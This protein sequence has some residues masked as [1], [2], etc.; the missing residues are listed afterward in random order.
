LVRACDRQTRIPT[1]KDCPVEIENL[2][3]TLTELD[4][5][6]LLN[7]LRR[8]ACADRLHAPRQAI[9]DLLNASALVPSRAVSPDVVTM[10][11]QVLLQDIQTHQR[12][13]LTLCYPA[14]AEPAAGFVSVLS[15]VGGALLGLR[16]GSIARWPTPTGEQR[17]AEIL[18][19]LF[20]P[21]SSGD[22][23]M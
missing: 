15:P 13:T 17:A 23:A 12:N 7:L 19:I 1:L 20:Q 21:E 9:E 22:Y 5:V 2:E 14:D 6:R 3:R 4:H 8:D 10:Y 18:A 16:A 11:S